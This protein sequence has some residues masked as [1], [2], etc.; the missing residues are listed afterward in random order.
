MASAK[1]FV[2]LAGDV[3]ILKKLPSLLQ[4]HQI[5]ATVSNDGRTFLRWASLETCTEPGEVVTKVLELL[6]RLAALL[7]V[8]AGADASEL[9]VKNVFWLDGGRLKQRMRA[10]IDINVISSKGLKRL[11]T[12]DESGSSLGSALLDL[13]TRND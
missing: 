12:I 5:E 7:H 9:T 3:Q 11:G 8:Y 10:T 6:P 2:E 1:W 13:S 4:G